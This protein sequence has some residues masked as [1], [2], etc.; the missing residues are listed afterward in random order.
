MP[1]KPMK[2]LKKTKS[3]AKKA[4][5][6]TTKIGSENIRWDLTELYTGVHDPKLET[7]L[8]KAVKLMEGFHKAHKGKLKSTLGQALDD[9][10]VIQQHTGTIGMYLYLLYSTDATNQDIQKM[11]AKA[12][13]TF[14]AASGNY[15]TFFDHELAGLSAADYA[16]AVKAH[17]TAQKHKGMLDR[18]RERAKYLL[19]EN[20]ERALTLRS[21]FGPDEWSEY[22]D[23]VE[24]ETKFSFRG[25]KLS[26]EQILDII[27]NHP[28]ADVRLA[29]MKVLNEGLTPTAKIM[30]RA[31]NAI[32]GAKNVDDG[33]RGYA[34]VMAGRNKDNMVEDQVVEALHKA[35]QTTGAKY[36]R[37]YY[38]LVAKLMGKKT[39]KW[40]DR[41]AK[42]VRASDSK[43]SW[44]EALDI[45]FQ[46]YDS[47]SPTLGK[48]VREMVSK[49]RVHAA[50]YEGKT[51]GAYNYSMETPKG[52][53]TYTFI[54]YQG[55]PRD[56]ATLAHEFGHG[57]HG[58]LAGQAVGALEMH[59][60]M[61]YAETAS[62]F[63]EMV[64]FNN[65]LSKAGSD[66]ERLALL[67]GKM[68]DFL[69][70]VVRQISFSLFEQ[71]CHNARKNGKLTVNDFTAQ[72]KAVTEELYGKDGD[73]FTYE[74]LDNLWSYVG[75]FLRPFYVYAYAFGELLTQSLYAAKDKVG[76]TFEPLYLD[77]LRS[78]G[79]K[80][81][82]ELLK[83]FGLDPRDPQ[84]WAAGIET[85]IGAWIAQ[86]EKL[87]AKGVK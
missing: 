68:S 18:T 64:T 45:V 83:P 56:V 28:K 11:R 17:P 82:V 6:K 69:N 39:L 31:L 20:V 26:Q 80:D 72:W 21:P 67:M 8:T 42:P 63:G 60:P 78:G 53:R 36:A 48:L 51:S 4:V 7:D 9:L 65:L 61:A 73:V 79:S 25:K 74:H 62:I 86:A 35:V 38:R 10:R 19:P 33:E 47:F 87:V 66:K 5:A 50:M 59:A 81:A 27:T 71:R 84:F 46:A 30:A 2:V 58:M 13:E 16:A 76:P 24:V 70:S 3:A 37:R 54:N 44:D 49:Q 75:H 23:E 22:L 12:S 15:L 40:S 32:L 77:L 14:A 1:A 55:S 34:H 57:V 29:A 85:S 41:N 52:V 43:V